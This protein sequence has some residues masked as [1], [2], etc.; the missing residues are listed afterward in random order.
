MVVAAVGR[1]T[2]K[3]KEEEAGARCGV[4]AISALTV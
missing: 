1:S 3:T 2:N 4:K